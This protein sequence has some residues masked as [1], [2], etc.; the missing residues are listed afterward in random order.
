MKPKN[1]NNVFA[2]LVFLSAFLAWT[3]ALL[4]LD[5]S[6]IGADGS[7]V[8]F[9]TLNAAVHEWTGV[10]LF[11]YHLTDWLGLVPIFVGF[12]FALLG[13]GQWIQ[14]KKLEKVDFSLLVLGGFYL[15]VIAF[16][17]LFELVVINYRPILISGVLEVSY[18]SSTTLL[19]ITVMATAK[20]QFCQ[21]IRRR[22]VRIFLSY[23]ILIFIAFMVLGR[24]FSGVH[25]F[26]DIIGGALLSAGLIFLYRSFFDWKRENCIRK[27]KT[28][29]DV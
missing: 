5:R 24:L 22:A 7:I 27:S 8:G 12:G 15:L 13:L 17:L 29:K 21:R 28:K 26:T 6:P 23:S 3:I 10:H 14:R 9:A 19:V 11:L 4:L 20:M 1:K 16:Y 18:P 2:S 25:W